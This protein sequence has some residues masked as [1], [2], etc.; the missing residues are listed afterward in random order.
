MKIRSIICIVAV[1]MIISLAAPS[2]VFTQNSFQGVGDL[3]GGLFESWVW[4]VSADGLT[5]VGH[6]ES[7][8]SGSLHINQ[9]FRWTQPGG[10]MGLGFLDGGMESIAQAVSEDGSAIVGYATSTD[11]AQGEA[12][13]WVNSGTMAGLGG[14]PGTQV[15]SSRAT[16]VAANGGIITGESVA[17]HSDTQAFFYLVP[18][19]MTGVGYLPGE[20]ESRAAD[21]CYRTSDAVIVG[22]SGSEA[23]YFITPG[24][25]VGMG[26]LTGH[27]TSAAEAISGNGDVIVGTCGKF[28]GG[29]WQ[30][31]QAFRYF[32]ST[33]TMGGLGELDIDGSAAS[34]VSGDGSIV[35]GVSGGGPF[36]WDAV[37]GMRD[38]RTVM[39]NEYG[40][41]L[42]GWTLVDAQ[43]ISDDGTVIVGNGINPSGK[44]EGWVAKLASKGWLQVLDP[45][46]GEILN[47]GSQYEIKWTSSGFASPTNVVNIAYSTTGPE[48]SAWGIIAQNTGDDGSFMWTVPNVTSSE[49]VI[50]IA[51]SYNGL[52]KDMRDA[53][54]TILSANLELTSPN[55]GENWQ[56]GTT[57]TI[58]WTSQNIPDND[59]TIEYS[60]DNGA[61]Y[62][63]IDFFTNNEP[64]ESYSWEVPNSPSSLCLVRISVT[65]PPNIPVVDV[66]D[67]TFTISESGNTPQD[68]DVTVGLGNGVSVTFD[69]VTGAGNTTLDIKYSGAPPPGGFKI[70][71]SSLPVY[72]DINTTATFDGDITIC[73]PYDDTG[74]TPAEETGLTLHVY[75]DPPGSWVDITVPPVD[76]TGNKIYGKVSHLTDFAI[77]APTTSTVIKF[78]P[79][80]S[81][82]RIG[83]SAAVDVMIES[84]ADLGSFEFEIAYDGAIVQIAQ[85]SDVVLGSILGST[86]RTGIPVGPTIDNVVGSVIYGA[87]SVGGQN[88]A[89][90]NGVLA[91][92][93]WTALSEGK[94]ILD[95]K[96]IKVSDTQ[97][98]ERAVVAE[99][100]EI[101][102]TS[103]FWADI[104]GDDDVDIIDVQLV[105]AHW[106]TQLGSA[107]YDAVCDVD[108]AGLGDGDVDIIDVQ[109]VASWW[110]QPL[111]SSSDPGLP[112]VILSGNDHN[113]GKLKNSDQNLRLTISSGQQGTYGN[114]RTINVLVE[115][116]VDIGAFQ[117]DIVLKQG[118]R[119]VSN[120]EL[121]GFLSSSGNTVSVIGPKRE[122]GGTRIILGAFSYGRNPGSRGSG[123]LARIELDEALTKDAE[124]DF[125][126]FMIVDSKGREL[127]QFSVTNSLPNFIGDRNSPK[128][129]SLM[130]NYPN[131]FNP[132]TCI[133]FE[134]P[135]NQKEQTHVTLQIFNMQGQRVR[136]LIDGGK[137][138]G[139][140]SVKWDGKNE[141]GEMVLSGMYVYTLTAGNHKMSRKMLLLK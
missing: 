136:T 8:I 96:N 82:I 60:T 54:F 126:N 81:N 123:I 125:E 90:G 45:N 58:N 22:S 18:F 107:N 74:M 103:R 36:I 93:T 98:T 133:H 41:D 20:S 53:E 127:K 84:A 87:A 31:G 134:L 2:T 70:I 35:V 61:N 85:S 80:A 116:A 113:P 94:S 13:R 121:G 30:K 135:A 10:I 119:I 92:I 105:A 115:N 40:L 106:N 50:L 27:E 4:D 63:F 122:D 131:P 12:F 62:N 16:G 33:G 65:M 64:S 101:N 111:P 120:V 39:E 99:D 23:F 91:T 124:L 117:F 77:M 97:G 139:R 100:G 78:N 86:G 114:L 72:F 6:S 130:Q 56:A 141:E 138:S 34:D 76:I 7:D 69:N 66:S 79:P 37:N 24:P 129:F 1:T 15:T 47:A 71:P 29:I 55:G 19:G 42:G 17:N 118:E 83:G 48:P 38:L 112:G 46:G 102:V 109:L 75:E 108:N 5:V 32:I 59:V 128:K 140:H 51:N 21:I 137:T 68:S 110:N 25:M 89:S 52:I 73:I 67:A 28:S 3:T 43:A 104:D 26:V 132:E 44:K 95:L 88:G 14:L 49:C 9:A 57:Q 11:F